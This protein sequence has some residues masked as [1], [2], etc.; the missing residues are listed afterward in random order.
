[1]R[2]ICQ[3]RPMIVV[4]ETFY[5]KP[6]QLVKPKVNMICGKVGKYEILKTLSS[7]TFFKIKL[8]N[9][10]TNH[11]E[12]AIKILKIDCDKAT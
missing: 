5:Q 8:A 2:A 9:D 6:P 10:V 12:V 4:K 7:G 11:R 3:E 1:M